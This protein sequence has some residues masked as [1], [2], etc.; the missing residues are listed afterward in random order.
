MCRCLVASAPATPASSPEPAPVLDSGMVPGPGH[1]PVPS[2]VQVPV[3]GLAAARREQ[4]R[5]RDRRDI[6]RPGAAGSATD[7]RPPGS[8]RTAR[9]APAAAGSLAAAVAVPAGS[10]PAGARPDAAGFAESESAGPVRIP[11][12]LPDPVLVRQAYAAPCPVAP[13]LV[14]RSRVARSLVARAPVA[15]SPGAPELAASAGL[16]CTATAPAAP[17]PARLA[18][19]G[20]PAPRRNVR[21]VRADPVRARTAAETSASPPGLRY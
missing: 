18:A 17:E 4:A 16:A 21:L 15:R 1:V 14:A 13:S 6:R 2:Q 9:P 20:A 10:G 19:S 12:P 11:A 7:G 8:S 5:A 3:P